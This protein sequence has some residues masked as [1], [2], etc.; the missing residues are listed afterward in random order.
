[1]GPKGVLTSNN[2]GKITRLFNQKWTNSFDCNNKNH[3]SVWDLKA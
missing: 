2:Y 1:M 3:S